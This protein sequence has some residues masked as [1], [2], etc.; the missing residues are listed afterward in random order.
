VDHYVAA[1]KGTIWSILPD[2]RI[3]DITH[4]VPPQ[5]IHTGAFTLRQVWSCFPPGTIHVAVVDPG[6]GTGRSI[7]LATYD[8]RFLVAPDNGLV[9]WVHRDFAAQEL[10]AVENPKFFL[11]NPSS[12]FHG[13]DIMAPVAAHLASG[14]PP[15]KF[16]PKI[17][18]PR[19]LKIQQ[20]ANR[21]G[22]AL[23]G[24]IIHVDR[25]GNLVTNIHKEQ[26]PGGADAARGHELLVNGKSIGPL[27]NTF[28]DVADGETVA[29]IGSAGFVEVTVRNGSAAERFAPSVGVVIAA[30]TTE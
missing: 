20:R 6:V 10:R 15:S 29:M 8:D 27:R 28:S 11:P 7:L 9:T 19:F 3:A 14:V 22:G 1:M 30:Q 16:G 5:D 24:T 13:R 25:F 12:T 21:D 18:T 17:K 2:A 23:N 4:D 26:L